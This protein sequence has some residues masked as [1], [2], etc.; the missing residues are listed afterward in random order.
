LSTGPK[1]ASVTLALA[2]LPE[3]ELFVVVG[4]SRFQQKDF[5]HSLAAVSC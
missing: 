1:S 5:F 2:L 3:L 4:L